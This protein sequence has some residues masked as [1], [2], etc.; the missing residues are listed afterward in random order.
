VVPVARRRAARASGLAILRADSAFFSHDIIAARRGAAPG[1][2][3][4]PALPGPNRTRHVE[5]P[6]GP[7][8]PARA[9]T[10]RPQDLKRFRCSPRAATTGLRSNPCADKLGPLGLRIFE[11]T[12]AATP[13]WVRS[14]ATACC[15]RSWRVTEVPS[16]EREADQ[17]VGP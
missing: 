8:D 15:A 9:L 11:A 6:Y 10:G 13:T 14:T 2:P 16:R 12:S 7:A 5:E 4:Q 1:V 3:G 17:R